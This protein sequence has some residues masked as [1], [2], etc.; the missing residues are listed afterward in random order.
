MPTIVKK[1]E[2]GVNENDTATFADIYKQWLLQRLKMASAFANVIYDKLIALNIADGEDKEQKLNELKELTNIYL[3]LIGYNERWFYD[4]SRHVLNTE[5]GVFGGLT[6]NLMPGYLGDIIAN[7]E[8][9]NIIKANKQTDL[10]AVLA[11]VLSL[12]GVRMSPELVQQII[13]L[14]KK[15]LNLGSGTNANPQ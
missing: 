9:Y 4:F 1:P 15:Q 8:R 13:D 11:T 6:G 7:L 2:F 10:G 3:T 5:M 12:L 14:L